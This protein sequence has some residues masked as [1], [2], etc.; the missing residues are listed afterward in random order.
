V[1]HWFTQDACER[2]EEVIWDD[3]TNR[4]ISRAELELDDLLDE[5]ID[6]LDDLDDAKLHF[7][8]AKIT[9]ERPKR[10]QKV[11]SNP[12]EGDEDSLKTFYQGSDL[13]EMDGEKG[14]TSP[15]I[16]GST[17]AGNFCESSATVVE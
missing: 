15:T 9:V 6:W 4:P 16:G 11:Q 13:P 14:A 1:S 7:E 5:D 3:A 12:L 10:F 17:F 2:A 8:A